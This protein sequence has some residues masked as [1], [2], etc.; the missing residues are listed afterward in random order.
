MIPKHV[1]FY[2]GNGTMS[3][4]RYLTLATF[5]KLNP[6]WQVTLYH[7]L[8]P[9]TRKTWKEHNAQDFFSFHGVDYMD[10]IASLG[11]DIKPWEAPTSRLDDIAASH[12]SNFFKWHM[13]ATE[14][15]I[16]ADLD[17]LW[18]RPIEAWWKEMNT[19]QCNI[20]L[21]YGGGRDGKLRRSR[22][23]RRERGR[24][25]KDVP[26]RRGR[27]S[28]LSIGLLASSGNNRFFRDLFETALQTYD[29]AHYQC[30]GVNSI[31]TRIY[32]VGWRSS[33]FRRNIL[34]DIQTSYPGQRF[35][36]IPMDLVYHFDYN[37]L[38]EL[39][40]K[41]HTSSVFPSTT[42]G[43]HWYAGNPLSQAFNSLLTEDNYRQYNLTM[44]NVAAEVLG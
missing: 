40:L 44:C 30:V 18:F 32:G 5:R 2:W 20:A 15:G 23:G 17:I 16:Y 31:Y 10:R 14:G 22:P 35:C 34:Q 4:L 43:I 37:G 12:K 38:S 1:F 27:W 24:K 3:W 42:L 11:I 28:W 39:F 19:N 36:N 26:G 8:Q 29:P 33:I 41:P 9:V 13:L 25:N 7:N 21:C 6:D